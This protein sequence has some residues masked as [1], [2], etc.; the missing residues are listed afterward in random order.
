MTGVFSACYTAGVVLPGA[1]GV[2]RYYHRGEKTALDRWNGGEGQ[3]NAG[4]RGKVG[5]S[6]N[7]MPAFSEAELG[8]HILAGNIVKANEAWMWGGEGPLRFLKSGALEAPP[9]FGAGA[10]WGTVPSPWR[11]DSLHVKLAGEAN[12]NPNPSPNP[13]QWL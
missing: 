3:A 5:V 1:V 12:P 11:K 13:D 8:K 2:A 4:C 6:S 10:T 9:S 7:S